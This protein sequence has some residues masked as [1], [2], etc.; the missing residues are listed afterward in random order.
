MILVTFDID[1]TLLNIANNG[2]EYVVSFIEAFTELFFK[3]ENIRDYIPKKTSGM[4]DIA[5]IRYCVDHVAKDKD[6][7]ERDKI[8]QKY[9]DLVQKNFEKNFSGNQEL[10]VGIKEFLDILKSKENVIIGLCTG[11]LE[12]VGEAK[13]KKAGILDYFD[14]SARGFGWCDSRTDLLRKVIESVEE[15]HKIKLEKVIHI[16]DTCSDVEAA[17]SVGAIPILIKQWNMD[18]HAVC[19]NC[20][21]KDYV[22]GKDAILKFLL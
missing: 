15:K 21:V 13:L 20:T 17:Q 18:K 5:L 10:A 16:G 14:E 3:P 12:K 19:E 8:V 11:N 9:S 7:D 4:T 2:K 6:Q 22:S 1:G